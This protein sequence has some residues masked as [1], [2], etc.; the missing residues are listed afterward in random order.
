MQLVAHL[1]CEA[2]RRGEVKKEAL[3]EHAFKEARGFLELLWEKFC[4]EVEREV[5]RAV[6]QGHDIERRHQYAADTLERL[7]HLRKAGEKYGFTAGLLE[8]FVKEHV[9]GGFWR[10]LFS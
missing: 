6:C 3:A 7:G 4:S 2:R 9:Q 8:R 1:A 5:L 10:K